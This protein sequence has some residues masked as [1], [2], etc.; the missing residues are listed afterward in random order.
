MSKVYLALAAGLAL[1]VGVAASSGAATPVQGSE[2]L[3]WA[4]ALDTTASGGAAITSALS[5]KKC[6][7]VSM[8]LSTTSAQVVT[9]FDGS[10]G[11]T[12][13]AMYLA[14]NTPTEVGSDILGEGMKTTSGNAV[15]VST[16]AGTVSGFLRFR[17][18]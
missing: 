16:A 14:A 6:R 10:G 11:D 15:Y 9:F 7:V 17:Y 18:E 1:L 12:I 5:G 13:G 2:Q 3:T 4:S 8:K